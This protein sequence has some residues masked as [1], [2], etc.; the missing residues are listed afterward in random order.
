MV[1]MCESLR[2]LRGKDDPGSP[3]N[4]LTPPP[5]ISSSVKQLRVALEPVAT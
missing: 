3:F 2:E 1:E 5:S 4:H